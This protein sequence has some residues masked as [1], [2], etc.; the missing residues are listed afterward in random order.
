MA[1]ADDTL[2]STFSVKFDD[3]FAYADT[4]EVSIDVGEAQLPS[5]GELDRKDKREIYVAAASGNWSE[6][7]SCCRIHPYW[8]QIPMT[9]SR[10]TALHIAVIMGKT[11]SVQKLISCMNMQDLEIR[12]ADRNTPFCLAAITGNVRI[13]EILLNKNGRLLWIRGRKNMLPI[14]LASS[15]GHLKITEF[16]LQKTLKDL[17]DL[18]NNLTFEEEIVKLFFFTI[19]NNLYTVA[20][21]LLDRYPKLVTVENEDRSTPLE[22]LAQLSLSKEITDHLK[23]VSS[24]FERMEEVKES[25]NS[26]QLS[27]AMFDAAKSGNVMIL[28]F[29]FKYHPYLIFE[30]SSEK[31]SLLHIAILYRQE[32]IYR[33]ILSKGDSKDLMTQLVDFEGNNVLHLA[34]KLRPE[35]TFALPTEHV[36][37]RSEELWF[38][39]VE[40]IVPPAMKTMR[41]KGGLTPKE[42]FYRSHK[43][44]HTKS[45]SGVRGSANTLLVVATLIISLGITG[46]MTI[47]IDDI[48][49]TITPMFRKKTWYTLFFVSISIGTYLCASSILFYASIILPTRW[50]PEHEY[51]GLVQTKLEFGN[52][53]LFSSLGF[54][55]VAIA[56]GSILIFDFLPNWIFYFIAGIGCIPLIVHPTLDYGLWTHSAT[57]VFTFCLAALRQ[58]ANLL[59]PIRG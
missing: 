19:T 6:T 59:S 45:V 53:A 12:M 27:R 55:F 50:K 43:E 35:P 48:D 2:G 47:P 44:L 49:S 46:A 8:W 13:A 28:E 34:G 54:M 23:L 4:E 10:L 37:M 15:A 52:M 57:S 3:I 56:S 30:V 33:L 25:L 36:L 31:R 58:K 20:S 32:D 11:S 41:N 18:N 51:V 38:Q 9:D 24:M 17:H 26:E 40:Q 14:Q 29:L 21:D 39:K 5:L 16:L 42:E 1:D 7:S 22:I